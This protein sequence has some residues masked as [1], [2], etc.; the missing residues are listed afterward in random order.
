M[1]HF[2]IARQVSVGNLLAGSDKRKIELFN[3]AMD[4][5]VGDKIMDDHSIGFLGKVV[6]PEGLSISGPK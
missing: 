6:P 5:E 4:D 1:Y 3:T 2:Y